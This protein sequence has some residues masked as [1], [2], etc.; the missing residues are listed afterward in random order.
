MGI[1]Y[2]YVNLSK[3]EMFAV[4]ALGGGVRRSALGRTLAAR[5]FH[6]MLTS[7]GGRWAGDSVAIIGDDIAPDWQRIASEF[8]NIQ[9]NAILTVFNSDGFEELA[10]RATTDSRLMLQLCYLVSTGQAPELERD[11]NQICDDNYRKRYAALSKQ[12]PHFHGINLIP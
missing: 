2:Y 9:A 4:D 8:A 6:L 3:S 1:Y 12:H 5:A 11:L 7:E 10:E